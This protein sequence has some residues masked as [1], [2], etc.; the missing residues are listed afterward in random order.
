MSAEEKGISRQEFLRSLLRFLALGLL[1]L[2]L[3]GLVWRSQNEDC[4]V[5]PVCGQCPQF[6]DCTLPPARKARS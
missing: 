3:G 1:G 5:A 2:G 6:G 4:T